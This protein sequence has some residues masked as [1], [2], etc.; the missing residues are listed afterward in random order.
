M[1]DFDHL[2]QVVRN[3]FPT[4]AV[5]TYGVSGLPQTVTG[6]YDSNYYATLQGEEGTSTKVTTLAVRIADLE[7]ELVRGVT[8]ITAKGIDYSVKDFREDS[9]GMMVIDLELAP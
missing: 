4:E 5:I 9:E 2:N 8:L 6:I 7:D 3:T 1:V